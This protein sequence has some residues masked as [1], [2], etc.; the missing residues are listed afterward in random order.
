MEERG[1][2]E[3]SGDAR[4]KEIQASI[5]EGNMM[6]QVLRSLPPSENNNSFILRF[7]EL[8]S[9]LE[10]YKPRINR[11]EED[12]IHSQLDALKEKQEKIRC[13]LAQTATDFENSITALPGSSQQGSHLQDSSAEIRNMVSI[14]KVSNSDRSESKLLPSTPRQSAENGPSNKAEDG[15]ITP[16]FVPENTIS[17]VATAADAALSS[18]KW[19]SQFAVQVTKLNDLIE[20]TKRFEGMVERLLDITKRARLEEPSSFLGDILV[21]FSELRKSFNSLRDSYQ[22]MSSD[23][24]MSDELREIQVHFAFHY[25]VRANLITFT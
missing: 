23:P 7:E 3:T 18:L 11:A 14:K 8:I 20:D 2:D 10:A 13:L 25:H 16:R 21:R 19:S 15:N 12:E 6:L 4:L 5:A 17:N 1:S 9:R 24:Q 22:D